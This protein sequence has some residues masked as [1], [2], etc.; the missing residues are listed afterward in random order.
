M[1]HAKVKHA[2][3]TSPLWYNTQEFEVKLGNTVAQMQYKTNMN[4]YKHYLESPFN[5][6][7][8]CEVGGEGGLHAPQSCR[9]GKLRVVR[10]ADLSAFHW[11]SANHPS[12]CVP[13]QGFT[14][15]PSIH[16]P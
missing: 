16:I 13:G 2:A 8:K 7:D 5:D 15:Y 1:K 3:W 6:Y 14:A 10:I 9:F 12:K 11:V 4:P